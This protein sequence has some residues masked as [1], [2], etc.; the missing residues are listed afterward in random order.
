MKH[1]QTSDKSRSN[2]SWTRVVSRR[3]SA[4]SARW[5]IVLARYNNNSNS[6]VIMISMEKPNLNQLAWLVIHLYVCYMLHTIFDLCFIITHKYVQCLCGI[7]ASL[8]PFNNEVSNFQSDWTN[9]ISKQKN[10]H[11][12]FNVTMMHC[13]NVNL[14]YCKNVAVSLSDL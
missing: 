5:L 3:K 7:F 1:L 10:S 6:I 11:L 13:K 2:A 4:H 8:N 9:K 12:T 14:M